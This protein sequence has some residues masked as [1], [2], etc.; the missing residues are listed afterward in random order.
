MTKKTRQLLASVVLIAGIGLTSVTTAHAADEGT[1]S[2]T[3]STT[4]NVTL[5]AGEDPENPGAGGVTLKAAPYVT[6]PSTEIDG[7][8]QTISGTIDAGAHTGTNDGKLTVVNAGHKTSWDVQVAAEKFASSDGDIIGGSTLT[9]SGGKVVAAG[10]SQLP[11]DLS[12][13]LI[14]NT[15]SATANQKV[16]GATYNAES[17]E[18]VGSFDTT[19]DTAKLDLKAGNV[20]GDYQSTL[21]W[22]LTN[23]PQA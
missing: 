19:Y 13:S 15:G 9:L 14:F 10:T 23:T 7:K 11:S 3:Q 1:A 18:G 20:A 4:G 5:T 16:I 22:T 12:T 8:D 21:T 2:T 6:V 17:K